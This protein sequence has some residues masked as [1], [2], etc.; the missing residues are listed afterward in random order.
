MTKM[1]LKKTMK[2]AERF[3]TYGN[4]CYVFVPSETILRGDYSGIDCSLG[5]LYRHINNN[6][7]VFEFHEADLLYCVLYNYLNELKKYVSKTF[8]NIKLKFDNS[9]STILTLIYRE[10]SFIVVTAKSILKYSSAGELVDR[11]IEYIESFRNIHPKSSGE[12]I[13]EVRL[14]IPIDSHTIRIKYSCHFMNRI[15]GI[16]LLDSLVLALYVR[17]IAMDLCTT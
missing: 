5:S 9:I 8:C 12:Y 1:S 16:I 4:L 3:Y 7:I 13:N 2:I 6:F 14:Y 11:V 15:L 17:K 10:N